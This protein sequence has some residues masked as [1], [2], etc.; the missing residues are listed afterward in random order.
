MEVLQICETK[1]IFFKALIQGQI[2][3]PDGGLRIKAFTGCKRVLAHKHMYAAGMHMMQVCE[4]PPPL[5]NEIT[6]RYTRKGSKSASPFPPTDWM[7]RNSLLS[8]I[9]FA[10][11]QHV[12]GNPPKT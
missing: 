10:G 11:S 3:N 5:R 7:F 4:N 2:Y 6:H 8:R 12:E 1:S 9:L